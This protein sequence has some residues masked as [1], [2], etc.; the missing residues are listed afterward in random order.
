ME[1]SLELEGREGRGREGGS[2]TSQIAAR[3]LSDV[4]PLLRQLSA[5]GLCLPRP[6]SAS[7]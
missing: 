1:L 4:V 2:Q 6:A 5:R 3:A 7:A